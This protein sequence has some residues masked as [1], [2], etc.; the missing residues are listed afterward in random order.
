MASINAKFKK[1]IAEQIKKANLNAQELVTKTM[2]DLQ[3]R[4][5]EKSPVDEGRFRGNTVIGVKKINTSINNPDASRG[6]PTPGIRAAAALKGFAMGDT[7]YL[8]NSLP[9]ARVLEYGEY[10]GTGEKT[11]NGFSTQAP[12]GMFGVTALEFKSILNVNVRKL[13]K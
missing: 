13:K 9:Y 1:S 4:V 12:Q 11:I 6:D 5:D 2:L 8:T 3:K 7:L 10:P